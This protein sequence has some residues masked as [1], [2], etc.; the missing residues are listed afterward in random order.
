MESVLK[1]KEHFIGEHFGGGII[2][3]MNKAKDH[4]LI[5]DTAD[6]GFFPWNNGEYISTGAGSIGIWSGKLNTDKIIMAQGQTR[7]YAALVCSNST[8]NGYSDWV[9]P[10]KNEL[11]ALYEQRDVVGGFNT[12]LGYWTSSQYSSYG[13]WWQNLSN[14]GFQNVSATNT[15]DLVRAIRA[16]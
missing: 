10:S 8:R 11:N 15:G 6:L 3:W 1:I 16:F 4:G 13:A 14:G 5:A 7:N 12:E 2:F 9:L